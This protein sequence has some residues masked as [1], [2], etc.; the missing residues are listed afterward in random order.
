M[1]F[2]SIEQQRFGLKKEAVRGTA[3]TAPD[4]WYPT[5]GKPELTYGLELLEDEGIRGSFSPYTPSAGLKVGEGLIPLYGDAQMLG[6][7]LLSL[8]GSVTSAQQDATIA[9]EHVFTLGTSISKPSYTL[10]L[11][12]NMN[13]LKYSLAVCQKMDFKSGVDSLIEVD[14]TWLFKSEETGSIGTPS[15]PTQQY[16]GFQHVL[17]SIDG[18][19][20]SSNGVKDWN[21]T[22]NNQAE[23]VRTL[24][25][26]QD[27]GDIVAAMKFQAE[28]NF[29]IYFQNI[30]TRDKFL[31]NQQITL[32]MQVIGG[33]I[34]SGQSWT[35]DINLYN[36]RYKAYPYGEDN[37]LLAAQVSFNAYYSIGDSK[38]LD[39]TLK[40][41]D[42]SY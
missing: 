40:N 31:A 6:E 26:S 2:F 42:T 17:F 12:R 9:Y 21:L 38:Q 16:L 33:L 1:G 32:R 37:V 35:L 27:T 20:T 4:K 14:T 25:Q 23:R 19:P 36:V 5:R 7:A 34:V 15:Y 24:N 18:G 29:T 39:V 3:E 8:M 10:F 11:D 30:G 41:E 22:L 28:G 13:V